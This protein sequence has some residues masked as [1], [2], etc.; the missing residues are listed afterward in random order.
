[1]YK[2]RIYKL[3]EC[4]L[5]FSFLCCIFTAKINANENT[6]DFIVPSEENIQKV[7]D[8][9]KENFIID[10]IPEYNQIVNE[11]NI[12]SDVV[13]I[14]NKSRGLWQITEDMYVGGGQLTSGN[15]QDAYIVQTNEDK[16]A[17]LKIISDNPYITV[18]LCKLDLNTMIAEGTNFY[19][20]GHDNYAQALGTMLAGDY[21]LMVYSSNES[22]PAGN[23]TLMWNITNPAGASSIVDINEDLTK[24]ALGY[25]DFNQP[26]TPAIF[27]NGSNWLDGLEWRDSQTF[28]IDYGHRGL[29]QHISEI[30]VRN[31]NKGSYN[32]NKKTVN[33]A[34]FIEVG[35]DS[36]WT[37]MNSY[38][39]NINGGVTHWMDYFD[40][41]GRK[42]PRR[43]DEYDFRDRYHYVVIDMD[44]NVVVDFASPYN[45]WWLTGQT[46]G[47]ATFTAT[48]ILN[49]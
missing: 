7:A 32:T 1:M 26:K 25:L 33:N 28:P 5:A 34:L 39:Q 4:I 42:T 9:I 49:Q 43:L 40:A 23:Y 12:S 13:E 36:L 2:K 47:S 18:R 37:Y 11:I 3:F 48:N 30:T 16:A 41:S 15:V 38:Y 17:A 22:Y 31:V 44:K 24:V 27:C 29:G 46:T 35:V 21:A 19:D 14:N 10:E 20:A 45:Y 6:Q 8:E